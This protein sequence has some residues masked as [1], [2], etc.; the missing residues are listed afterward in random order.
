MGWAW[1]VAH[2][3]RNECK[4]GFGYHYEEPNAGRRII[5]KRVFEKLNGV[6]WT[7]LI[8]FR[9]GTSGGLL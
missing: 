1:H 8:W 3:G 4:C 5:L 2:V 7:G 6:L 9:I